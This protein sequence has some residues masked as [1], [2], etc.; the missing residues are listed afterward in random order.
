MPDSGEQ[1][2]RFRVALD[3]LR[4]LIGKK[5]TPPPGDPYAC[6]GALAP[7][8]EGTQRR[9]GSRNRG[10]LVSDLSS[11]PLKAAYRRESR[12]EVKHYPG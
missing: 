2:S 5:P 6:D 11:T 9:G 8:S 12:L 10:R 7:R 3:F 4:R 1:R